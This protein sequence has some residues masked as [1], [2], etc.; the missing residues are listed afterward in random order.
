MEIRGRGLWGR[1]HSLM[2]NASLKLMVRV[3]LVQH[4]V[5]FIVVRRQDDEDDNLLDD[6]GVGRI[7]LVSSA[8]FVSRS[9]KV[10]SA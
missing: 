4:V 2:E 7:I 3:Q 9:L 8:D 1:H 5:L 6:L 10:Y